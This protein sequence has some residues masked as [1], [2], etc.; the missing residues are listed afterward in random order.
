[1]RKT[2]FVKNYDLESINMFETFYLRFTCIMMGGNEVKSKYEI[3]MNQEII[4]LLKLTNTSNIQIY[5]RY[6]NKQNT[7]C[8]A[9]VS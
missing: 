8:N 1:M 4:I 3:G 6:F 7:W 2:S 9:V 5:M